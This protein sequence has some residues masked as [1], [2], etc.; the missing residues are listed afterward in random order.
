M[1]SGYFSKDVEEFLMLLNKHHVEYLIVGGEAVIYYGYPRLTGDI[2]IF[3]NSADI[4]PLHQALLEFWQWSIPGIKRPNELKKPG[5]IIQFGIPPNRLDLMNSID[6]VSFQKAWEK[7][8]TEK[9]LLEDEEIPIYYIGLEDL[10]INKRT[11]S[12]DKDKDDASYL[13]KLR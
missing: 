8:T 6:G 1:K 2:D 3:Y 12:R 7:K 5:Y 9:L 4:I 10:L 11:S 13:E